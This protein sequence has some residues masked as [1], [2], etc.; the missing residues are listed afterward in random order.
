VLSDDIFRSLR[1]ATD[2]V[3]FIQVVGYG[4]V[5]IGYSND[6]LRRLQGMQMNCPFKLQI[7]F[8]IPGGEQLERQLL[9]E[10]HA[11]NIHGE[12]FWPVEAL[13]KRI[14]E[15]ELTEGSRGFW[16]PQKGLK[17]KLARK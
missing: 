8:A 12:W 1:R 9:A 10:F 14:R 13:M 15:L 11:Y 17:R 16:E 4:P 7:L 6:P 5:K 3:Y 2:L